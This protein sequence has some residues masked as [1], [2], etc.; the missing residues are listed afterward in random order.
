MSVKD[1]GPQSYDDTN[2][3]NGPLKCD[4][5]KWRRWFMAIWWPT[6]I[7]YSRCTMKSRSPHKSTWHLCKQKVQFQWKNC[8]ALHYLEQSTPLPTTSHSCHWSH[9]S[10][11]DT[12]RVRQKVWKWGLCMIYSSHRD[13]DDWSKERRQNRLR[14]SISDPSNLSVQAR[15][16]GLQT[17]S[18]PQ[19]HGLAST[20][21]FILWIKQFPF[22]LKKNPRL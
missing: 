1:S 21:L 14:V 4:R 9:W 20:L 10:H 22:K 5:L 18:Q 16:V 8:T 7:Q 19:C 11:T 15:R 6:Y 12:N 2:S 13:D 17:P 3:T